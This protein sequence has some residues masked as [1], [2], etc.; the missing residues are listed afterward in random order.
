MERIIW[1]KN[2]DPELMVVIISYWSHTLSW[3]NITAVQTA[4]LLLYLT[5]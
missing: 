1:M 2:G 4:S 3:L 5:R